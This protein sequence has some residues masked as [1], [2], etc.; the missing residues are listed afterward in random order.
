[1]FPD[2]LYIFPNCRFGGMIC[3]GLQAIKFPWQLENEA[4][5]LKN[6]AQPAILFGQVHGLLEIRRILARGVFEE[7]AEMGDVFKS[8]FVSDFLHG[9]VS[10][11]K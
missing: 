2:A 9:F 1:M 7:F 3:D 11:V 5:D 8:Q 10:I 4:F 6:T